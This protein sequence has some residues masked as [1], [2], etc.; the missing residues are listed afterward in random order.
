MSA[1]I[2]GSALSKE[3][4][5]FVLLNMVDEGLLQPNPLERASIHVID[6]G[7]DAA[8]PAVVAKA[9][10]AGTRQGASIPDGRKRSRGLFG[11]RR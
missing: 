6:T 8:V 7:D 4:A 10:T 3:L 5:A 9:G 11:R 1:G 2:D